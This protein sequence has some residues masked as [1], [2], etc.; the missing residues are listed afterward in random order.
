M[1]RLIHLISGFFCNAHILRTWG[2]LGV[3][4]VMYVVAVGTGQ[5]VLT[6]GETRAEVIRSVVVEQTNKYRAIFSQAPLRVSPLL[7]SAA[8]AKAEDMAQRGYFAHNSPDG[9]AP[10]FWFAKVGYRF[11]HAGENLAV[12][13]TDSRVLVRAWMKSESHRT[14]LLYA[15]YTEVG[16]GIATG[17][18]KGKEEV[19]VVQFF[20]RPLLSTS[21]TQ[22]SSTQDVSNLPASVFDARAVAAQV[23]ASGLSDSILE[24]GISVAPK[25]SLW[26]KILL[27][28]EYFYVF[29]YCVFMVLIAVF[30]FLRQKY[31]FRQYPVSHVAFLCLLFVVGILC[32]RYMVFP[33]T[34]VW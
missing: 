25:L 16:V 21:T 18:Y 7:E 20:A 23:I 10:W 27:S 32:V 8:Q 28:P 19:Y 33:Y 31:V 15:P 13:F 26:E 12:R 5:M 6:G 29:V 30:V 2:I 24:P 9:L 17:I 11:T 3:M 34:V 1:Q 14:N 22:I 4:V